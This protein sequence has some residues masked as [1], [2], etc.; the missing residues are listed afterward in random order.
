[1]KTHLFLALAALVST[2][3]R[4]DLYRCANGELRIFK[5]D[6]GFRSKI[7]G[8][9][10]TLLVQKRLHP[11]GP[12]TDNTDPKLGFAYYSLN[13]YASGD[14]G[15]TVFNDYEIHSRHRD[16]YFYYF[17][18]EQGTANAKLEIWEIANGAR[19]IS[20]GIDI[21]RD[22]LVRTESFHD[23]IRNQ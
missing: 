4:A 11:S 3:A 1:M 8:A 12:T 13:Y 16:R 19:D 15:W 14:F 20:Q 17:K 9:L 18:P 2:G 21:T 7:T 22:K 10:E 23:C 5:Q 6:E